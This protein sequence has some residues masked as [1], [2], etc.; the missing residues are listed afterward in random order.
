MTN[1]DFCMRV[2]RLAT[3]FDVH[4]DLE[5]SVGEGGAFLQ[6]IDGNYSSDK[7]LFPYILCNDIFMHAADGEEITPE[8]IDLL[9]KSLKD[10]EHFPD[11][12]HG[13]QLFVSR[14]RRMRPLPKFLMKCS[15]D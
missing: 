1:T 11:F 2:L 14:V 7:P 12:Y 3:R 15:P 9:E 6:P 8:N 13:T 10:T 5:W 4:D